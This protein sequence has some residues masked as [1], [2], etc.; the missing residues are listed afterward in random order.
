MLSICRKVAGKQAQNFLVSLY[1]QHL[2]RVH[3]MFCYSLFDLF[4]QPSPSITLF[5]LRGKL[6]L[7]NID[8]ND[9]TRH[10]D[11]NFFSI[12]SSPHPSAE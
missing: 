10:F 4:N 5:I 8:I 11:W 2:I 6:R 7:V 1:S 12:K 3:Q 9:M